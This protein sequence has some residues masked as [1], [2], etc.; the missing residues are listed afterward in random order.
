MRWVGFASLPDGVSFKC[1]SLYTLRWC[2]QIY[3][4]C[5]IEG[6]KGIVVHSPVSLVQP[7][8]GLILRFFLLTDR[9]LCAPFNDVS[10]V[11]NPWRIKDLSSYLFISQSLRQY[12]GA[13]NDNSDRGHVPLKTS[14]VQ[15]YLRL[16]I[17]QNSR[18]SADVIFQDTS[19]LPNYL[20]SINDS[21]G[22][23]YMGRRYMVS[24]LH[25]AASEQGRP[26]AL[27]AHCCNRRRSSFRSGTLPKIFDNDRLGN[28]LGKTAMHPPSS[29][30]YIR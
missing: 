22:T 19:S 5:R 24:R 20:G 25:S 23:Y 13:W 17:R 8:D 16:S 10:R 2:P 1:D 4:S 6:L 7:L 27:C 21:N 11:D 12:R 15:E 26:I 3:F 28:K 14:V 9:A 29:G 18:P 30:I